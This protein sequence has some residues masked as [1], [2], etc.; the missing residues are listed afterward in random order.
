MFCFPRQNFAH[1]SPAIN[2]LCTPGNSLN[3]RRLAR[4]IE[5]IIDIALVTLEKYHYPP[6]P[7]TVAAAREVIT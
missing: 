6:P 5:K 7:P 2:N 3:K 4:A 1:K